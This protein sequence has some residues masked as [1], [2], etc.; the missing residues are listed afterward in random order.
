MGAKHSRL[1][2]ALAVKKGG[3]SHLFKKKN[4]YGA[5]LIPLVSSKHKAVITTDVTHVIKCLVMIRK[6]VD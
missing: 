1:R 5:A 4:T 2:S 3:F 6:K